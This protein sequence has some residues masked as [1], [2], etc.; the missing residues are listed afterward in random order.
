L[1]E[2]RAE[3]EEAAPWR[4]EFDQSYSRLLGASSLIS[5]DFRSVR[6]S[7]RAGGADRAGRNVELRQKYLDLLEG[8]PTGRL[9]EDPPIS[10][11]PAPAYDP[12]VRQIRRDW[13]SL[14]QTMI[15]TVRMRNIRI[16]AEQILEDGIA[17]DFLEAGV[18]RGGA[19][20]YMRGILDAHSDAGRTVFVAASFAGLPQPDQDR[21]PADAGD[22]HHTLKELAVSLEDVKNNFAPCGLLDERVI[23]LN[24]WFM[25]TLPSSRPSNARACRSRT[26]ASSS[27]RP[28]RPGCPRP[29][30]STRSEDNRRLRMAN[31]RRLGYPGVLL[32]YRL[33]WRHCVALRVV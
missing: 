23:F 19:C 12:E 33:G 4:A 14:A 18:W 10:P 20:I 6:Q 17:G 27:T 1:A 16:L 26:S 3:G 22:P 5:A 8:A 31:H 11:L 13:P 24:G 15:G 2:L 9:Y 29:S 25:D 32:W 7:L 28:A 30:I 21:Y